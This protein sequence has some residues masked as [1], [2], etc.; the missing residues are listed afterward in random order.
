MLCLTSFAQINFPIQQDTLFIQRM[1]CNFI[2]ISR[3]NWPL[4]M[5]I[6]APESFQFGENTYKIIKAVKNYSQE[7]LYTFENGATA[8]Q[9][10]EGQ[11]IK[12]SFS[13]YEFFCSKSNDS[14]ETITE[15]F[16]LVEQK[17]S[18]NGGDANEFSK[19][20]N[21][22]LKYPKAAKDAG[23]QGRVM[24]QFTIAEDG[25]VK[26]VSVLRGVE[27]SLDAEAVRVVSSS[28][29]WSPGKIRGKPTEVTY[30]FPLIF[31]VT[32]N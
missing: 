24:L 1:T 11:L 17:P 15:R 2:E 30:T 3:E 14:G 21:A 18:F 10:N 9:T 20:V 22:H 26:N 8:L 25:T 16:Q 32:K 19:W 23:I 5:I 7:I 6:R 28:P 31:Q 4:D 12:F 13:N 27:P 29:K